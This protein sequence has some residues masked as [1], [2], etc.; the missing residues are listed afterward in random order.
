L[1]PPSLAQLAI[2][3]IASAFEFA[4]TSYEA[5]FAFLSRS[6]LERLRDASVSRAEPMLRIYEPR[7]RLHSMA[8]IGQIL[9]AVVMTLSFLYLIQP[10]VQSSL[11][12][13]LATFGTCMVVL[14]ASTSLARRIRFE[15]EGEDDHI[16]ALTLAYVPV[17]ALLVPLTN[18]YER[19]TRGESS[20]ADIKASKEEELRNMVD[21]EGET[22]VLE[23]GEREMIQSVF[24]FHDRVVREVMA[25]RVDIVAVE[26]NATLADLLRVA[27][28]SG[29]SRFPLYEDSL[30]QIRGIVY[31]KDLLHL[32]VQYRNL[33]LN[34][35]LVDFMKK[36][37]TDDDALSFVHEP[38]YVPET[39]KVDELLTDLR[40][41]RTRIAIVVDEYGGTAGLISTEDLVEEIVGELQDEY[42]EEEALYQW[43]KQDEVLVVNPRINIDELNELMETDLPADGFDTLG[44]FIYHR[45]G[46]VPEIGEHLE[47]PGLE[48]EILHVEGQRIA[49]VLMTRVPVEHESEL[50][51]SRD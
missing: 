3:L 10:F 27:K 41:A 19:I 35:P 49:K 5:T 37:S 39:K 45:L 33:D 2:F 31:T 42:D 15:E 7:H 46:Q 18:L 38:Y 26:Q 4:L 13:V 48:I 28:E 16:P 12:T 1:E 43:R 47:A 22:G 50:N 44:G 6:S 40:S 14:F 24:G 30:D 29:H 20:D 11:Y 21:A 34:T 9:G 25:P 23:E 36:P 8:R 32:I 51:R 17:H